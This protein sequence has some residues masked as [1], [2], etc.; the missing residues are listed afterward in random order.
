MDG[1]MVGPPL[2][3]TQGTMRNS[4]PP[5]SASASLM[6]HGRRYGRTFTYTVI[7][8]AH[9]PTHATRTLRMLPFPSSVGRGSERL[10]R[11]SHPLLQPAVVMK[12]GR[13][14]ER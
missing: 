8:Q 5:L 10:A 3:H 11:R 1:A 4:L 13:R 6:R 12:R 9:L 2:I 7:F 14:I